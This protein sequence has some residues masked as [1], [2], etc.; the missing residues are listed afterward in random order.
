M[1]A[2]RFNDAQREQMAERR[3]AGQSYARIARAFGCSESNVYWI[4]LA[5][6]ADH[7]NAKPLSVEI[8]GPMVVLRNGHAV[9]RY[10]REEDARLL[11]LEAEGNGDSAIGKILGRRP[12]SVRARLM[13]LARREARTEAA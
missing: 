3:E 6:G 4:C 9:R 5:L 8:R 2:R 11:A 1:P 12:N 13:T 7:P 10:T